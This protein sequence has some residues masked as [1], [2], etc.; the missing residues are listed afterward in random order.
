MQRIRFILVR[1]VRAAL[2]I[3][4]IATLN[5]VIVRM[6]PGDPASVIAGESGA[7]DPVFM[8][9]LRE[10]FRLDDPLPTQ[11][12]TYISGILHLD[13]GYSHRQRAAVTT[14]IMDRLG[15][16]LLLTSTGFLLALLFGVVLGAVAAFNRGGLID[17]AI[18]AVNLFLFAT[19]IYWIGLLGVLIFSAQL[20]WLPAYG[21][22]SLIQP[23][24]WLG[25]IADRAS[26]LMLPAL[27]L[28]L[29][30]AP[31]YARLMRASMLEI[32]DQEFVRLARSKG[33]SSTRIAVMH[34]MRNSM[35]PVITFAGIHAGH[36]L[37][38]S[39]LVE[40][41]FGWPGLGRLTLDS[42]LVRDYN[43]LLG[44]FLICSI[45]TILFN[46]ITD[47]LCTVVDPRIEIEG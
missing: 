8:A 35:L 32:R 14:L 30:Y 13:L 7:A 3:L 36:L 40:T 43:V 26:H 44:I 24:D 29:S 41:I 5:F 19:P 38:G 18:N 34:V 11:L 9:Q 20:N 12:W 1:V 28:G 4:L 15:A 10:E 6:A 22:A 33:L 16:T 47:L 39:I 21:A 45:L 17:R 31:I 23:R 2:L 25:F 42:M 37:G 46:L 27:T